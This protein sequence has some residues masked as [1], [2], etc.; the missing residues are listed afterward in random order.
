MS[1]IKKS[2]KC[3]KVLAKVCST[4]EWVSDG[5]TSKMDSS[6]KS[7][8]LGE[9]VVFEKDGF[10]EGHNNYIECYLCWVIPIIYVKI[11]KTG[12]FNLEVRVSFRAWIGFSFVL[13]KFI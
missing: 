13:I 2:I 8:F 6:Q 1:Y 11:L 3:K 9:V 12:D 5:I 10:G 7:K 4:T